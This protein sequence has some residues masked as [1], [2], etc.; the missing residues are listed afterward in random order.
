MLFVYIHGL[1]QQTS[2]S[3]YKKDLKVI[4]SI[5]NKKD[6]EFYY[7]LCP[8]C[9]S[10][11]STYRTRI[12]IFP[13]AKYSLSC[14]NEICSKYKTKF[15]HLPILYSSYDKANQIINKK[16]DIEPGFFIPSII[17]ESSKKT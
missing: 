10:I 4:Y 14:N 5:I 12:H 1:S 9:E 11:N 17:F 16:Q 13:D 15:E 8:F 6:S 2:R 3:N 7:Y